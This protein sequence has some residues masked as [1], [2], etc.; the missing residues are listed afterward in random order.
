MNKSAP[1]A[2]LGYA[3]FALTLWMNS[4]IPAGWFDPADA[5]FAHLMAIVL[6]G[7]VMAA[8][9]FL[10]ALRGQAIDAT[11]F[12]CFAAYWW[13]AALTA[14]LTIGGAPPYSAGM[15]G[16]YYIVWSFLAFCV[17]LAACRDGVARM[18]FALGLCLSL[19]A[20]ALAEW[21]HLG[22]LEVLGGYLGLVTAV[23]GIYI[24]GA[25]MVNSTSGHTI[26][27]LGETGAEPPPRS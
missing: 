26:L 11:L 14:R 9:G 2:A 22:A 12:L 21:L 10:Q 5:M 17:W 8:A 25:E 15:L 18:L 23:V 4:M 6:G 20:F 1:A 13:V 27:P 19:F 24:A 16:W 3:A 7:C